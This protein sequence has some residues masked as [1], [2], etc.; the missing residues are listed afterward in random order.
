M[1]LLVT[2][3][4]GMLGRAVTG[5]ARAE[6]H[7]VVAHTRAELDI[8]DAGALERAVAVAAPA[9]VVN[10][11]AWTDVDG[12]ESDPNGA[13]AVNADGAG[14][15]ARAAASAGAVLVHVS[16]DYVFAGDARRP[17][18]ESDPTGPRS[19]YGRSKLLGERAVL[20][21][22]GGHVVVRTSWLFGLGGRNFVE[23][24]L[25]LGAEREQVSVVT[26]QRGCP[27]FAGH[28]AGALLEL[29]ARGPAAAGIH[30]V[31]GTGSCSWNE[32]A[33]EIFNQAHVECRVEATDSEAMRRAAPRPAY[34]V[35][36]SERP[37]AVTLPPWQEGLRDYLSARNEARDGAVGAR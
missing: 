26:D 29:A 6:G 5:R 3:A 25:A 31:A 11:A 10:C 35:L 1:R 24:M 14:N 23:T 8:T 18:V 37:G 19:E 12:A 34:S 33:Q 16:T 13:R 15:V 7:D 32:F 27:T 9:V 20:E 21:A 28:L 36:S 2:G 22:A 17:Y 4:G 30:H